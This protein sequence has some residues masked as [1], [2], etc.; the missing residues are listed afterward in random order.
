MKLSKIALKDME[1]KTREKIL[2]LSSDL[3]RISWWACDRKAERDDLIE[4]FLILAKKQ[5]QTLGKGKVEEIVKEE[6]FAKWPKAKTNKK[7]KLLWAEEV[8]TVSLRL[9]HLAKT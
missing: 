6:I 3:R 7:D 9:K 5:K 2:N 1:S 8:L 4:R